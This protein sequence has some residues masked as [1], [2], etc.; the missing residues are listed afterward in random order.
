MGVAR[1]LVGNCKGGAITLIFSTQ[2][3]EDAKIFSKHG[4]RKKNGFFEEETDLSDL[5]DS[6]RRII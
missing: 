6:W 2:R 4:I 5:S 1:E 3:R